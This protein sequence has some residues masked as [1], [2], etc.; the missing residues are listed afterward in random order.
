MDEHKVAD[1]QI[2]L[3]QRLQGKANL[4][5]KAVT[6]KGPVHSGSTPVIDFAKKALESGAASVKT[7]NNPD[8]S[9]ELQQPGVN[10]AAKFQA[11]L[12]ELVAKLIK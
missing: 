3:W 1:Y 6:N 11:L 10:E 8:G 4:K 7:R 5:A 9:V 12:N 2:N